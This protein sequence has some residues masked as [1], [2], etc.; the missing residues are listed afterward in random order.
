M[1]HEHEKLYAN[2]RRRP[3]VPVDGKSAPRRLDRR[4][5]GG[6]IRSEFNAAI[7][8]DPARPT[9]R[10]PGSLPA[11][12]VASGNDGP[13]MKPSPND[14]GWV[15]GEPSKTIRKSGGRA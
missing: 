5:N 4:A 8:D 12:H 7:N 10:E 1:A 6:S 14:R 9:I 11:V 3:G 13:M 15:G 2:R